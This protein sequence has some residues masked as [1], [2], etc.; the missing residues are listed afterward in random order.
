MKLPYNVRVLL[1]GKRRE[2]VARFAFAEDAVQFMAGLLASGRPAVFYENRLVS[3]DL[4]LAR[5]SI[6]ASAAKIQQVLD[7]VKPQ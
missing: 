2:V 5:Q 4:Q 7:N 6:D 1:G 3:D